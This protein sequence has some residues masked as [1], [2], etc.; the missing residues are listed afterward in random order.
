MEKTGRSEETEQGK[1]ERDSVE[2]GQERKRE[3]G[4]NKNNVAKKQIRRER[5]HRMQL[6]WIQKFLDTSQVLLPLSYILGD[7]SRRAEYQLYISRIAR[8]LG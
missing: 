6:D 2:C 4:A 3:F 5:K 8:G 7:L 1:W